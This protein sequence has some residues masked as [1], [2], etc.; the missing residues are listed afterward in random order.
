M[1]RE[2]AKRPQTVAEYRV[3]HGRIEAE[4]ISH[5]ATFENECDARPPDPYEIYCGRKPRSAQSRY[6]QQLL[7][8]R[9]VTR[10]PV[11]SHFFG[12]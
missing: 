2:V 3:K 10:P 4:P 7:T 6:S 5:C 12:K 11:T 1:R 8:S 9:D